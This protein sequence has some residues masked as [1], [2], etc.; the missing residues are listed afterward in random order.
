MDKITIEIQ[1]NLCT[2][3]TLGAWKT[4]PLCR[5]LPDKDQ[6]SVRF[7]LVVI[8]SGW[9]LLT[10]GRWDR[11]DRQCVKLKYG[12]V[13][14]EFLSLP[15]ITELPNHPSACTI[16]PPGPNPIQHYSPL[17]FTLLI[18]KVLPLPLFFLWK[19]KKKF[20]NKILTFSVSRQYWEWQRRFNKD[21]DKLKKKKTFQKKKI[22]QHGKMSTKHRTNE[23]LDLW[24][25]Q[26]TS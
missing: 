14:K 10:G 25:A 22:F 26:E 20:L 4:W 12:H 2:P 17:I 7:W 8:T 13:K 23:S 19:V 15:N 18:F 1:S 5:G 3:T 21:S 9:H 11:F 24:H 16:I 6:W